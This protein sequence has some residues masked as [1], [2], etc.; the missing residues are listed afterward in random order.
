M[1]SRRKQSEAFVW[2]TK[3]FSPVATPLKERQRSTRAN[4][5]ILAQAQLISTQ[6]LATV[7]LQNV[8]SF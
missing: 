7:S 8:A 2:K 6:I 4:C 5:A 1:S 3:C